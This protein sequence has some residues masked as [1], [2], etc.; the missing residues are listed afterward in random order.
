[1][2]YYILELPM[3]RIYMAGK[4]THR[5][6]IFELAHLWNALEVGLSSNWQ[7]SSE[8]KIVIVTTPLPISARLPPTMSMCLPSQ[9]IGVTVP[10]PRLP[11]RL[12]WQLPGPWSSQTFTGWGDRERENW[13]Y[14]CLQHQR[15]TVQSVIT[16]CKKLIIQYFCHF[17][18]LWNP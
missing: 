12:K 17:L 8:N 14:S 5:M 10:Q 16:T 4:V 15:N 18:A 1:M 2:C 7:N 9:M 6:R 13:G 3:H 11:W